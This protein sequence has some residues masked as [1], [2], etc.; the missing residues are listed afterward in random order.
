MDDE[1]LLT[2]LAQVAEQMGFLTPL[3]PGEAAPP[4]PDALVVRVAFSGASSGVVAVAASRALAEALARN[5]L[6][7]DPAAAVPP[8]DAFDALAELAN[9]S[10]G[11]LLPLLHGDGEYRLAA[12]QPG[13]WPGNPAQTAFLECAEGTLALAAVAGVAA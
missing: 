7:L 3:G 5:L 12:P 6:A 11:N 2:V 8:A 9:V 1:R 4:G 13:T 10:T